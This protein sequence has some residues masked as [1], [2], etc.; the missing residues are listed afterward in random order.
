M[1]SGISSDLFIF[2]VKEMQIPLRKYI[3]GFGSPHTA[4]TGKVVWA[5]DQLYFLP[6]CSFEN[7][8]NKQTNLIPG[9]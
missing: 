9:S 7:K 1:S 5:L 3:H 8:T 2:L 4:A 6:R